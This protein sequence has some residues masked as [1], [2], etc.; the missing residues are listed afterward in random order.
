[1]DILK[2]VHKFSV[3]FFTYS[4]TI[5]PLASPKLVRFMVTYIFGELK[6]YICFTATKLISHCCLRV[7]IIS[8]QNH[9]WQLVKR[10]ETFIKRVVDWL[11][12]GHACIRYTHTYLS[13]R[14][15]VTRKPVD[16]KRDNAPNCDC[17]NSEEP[18]Y[19]ACAL[20]LQSGMAIV[21]TNA[22]QIHWHLFRYCS[23][24]EPKLRL[25]NL[26]FYHGVCTLLSYI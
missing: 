21:N 18:W 25:L 9:S 13:W 20:C 22:K 2:Y 3:T 7:K 11:P 16:D 12:P 19:F 17:V 24:N 1:M 4:I 8:Q 15:R 5:S 10:Q 23:I 26:H 6:V 14:A